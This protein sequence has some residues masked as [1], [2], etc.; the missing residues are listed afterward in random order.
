MRWLWPY[1]NFQQYLIE[2]VWKIF[3]SLCGLNVHKYR[4][5]FEMQLR[6]KSDTCPWSSFTEEL[7]YHAGDFDIWQ[8]AQNIKKDYRSTYFQSDILKYEMHNDIKMRLHHACCSPVSKHKKQNLYQ[9]R[10]RIFKWWEGERGSGKEGGTYQFLK[11]QYLSNH[12]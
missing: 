3:M 11:S 9:G 10:R 1:S 8:I 6:I 4:W 12:I 2:S 5:D 7:I